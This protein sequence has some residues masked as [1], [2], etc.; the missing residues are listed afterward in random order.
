MIIP[1]ISWH[2]YIAKY[3]WCT[4]WIIPLNSPFK[5]NSLSQIEIS[6]THCKKEEVREFTGIIHVQKPCEGF[7][8]EFSCRRR[9]ELVSTCVIIPRR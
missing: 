2:S 1:I 9:Q 3:E 7:C 5:K 6:S 4:W 8:E